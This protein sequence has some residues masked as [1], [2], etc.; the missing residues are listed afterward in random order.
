MP[1]LL[2]LDTSIPL[3]FFINLRVRFICNIRWYYLFYPYLCNNIRIGHIYV[4]IIVLPILCN[5]II[6]NFIKILYFIIIL[7]YWKCF[8][9]VCVTLYLLL[10]SGSIEYIP[11]EV[12]LIMFFTSSPSYSNITGY[13]KL[14]GVPN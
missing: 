14:E 6:I 7:I 3:F 1:N 5:W 8:V 12:Q 11:L 10:T 13:I 4:V 2:V 9:L